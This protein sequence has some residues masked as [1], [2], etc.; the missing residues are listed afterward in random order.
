MILFPHMLVGAAIGSK[1]HNY[2]IIL[3]LAPIFHFL[4]D[5]LPHWEYV[6]DMARELKENL[7]PFVSKIILDVGLAA[8]F[9]VAIFWN[10]DIKWYAFFGAFISIVPDG[11]TLLY[12]IL[13]KKVFGPILKKYADFHESVHIQKY[14][15]NPKR[16]FL[17]E[18][19]ICIAALIIIYI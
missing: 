8:I 4:C 15:N 1:I 17:I 2:W 5:R 18:V 16:N 13:P 12:F 7:G 6:D 9:I 3:V 14:K 11:L 10:S 19:T